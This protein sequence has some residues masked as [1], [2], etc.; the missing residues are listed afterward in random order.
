MLALL[1]VTVGGLGGPPGLAG[2]EQHPRP[3]RNATVF[4]EPVRRYLPPSYPPPISLK[5]DKRGRVENDHQDR[6]Y[7]ESEDR[8]PDQLLG[9]FVGHHSRRPH[10]RR[11]Y[12]TILR[13]ASDVS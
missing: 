6:R 2:T 9:A 13:G 1:I 5:T 10:Q 3:L 7:A 4:F 12:G 11:R 8:L